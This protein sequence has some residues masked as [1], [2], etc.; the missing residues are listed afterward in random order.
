MSAQRVQAPKEAQLRALGGGRFLLAGQ[1]GGENAG[2]L[3][4]EGEAAFRGAAAVEVDLSAPT[5]ADSAGLAV[6]L[7]W[8]AVAR[9]RGATLRYVGMPTSL[10]AV[11][12]IGEVEALLRSAEGL[13]A[14]QAGQAV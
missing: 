12:R 4:A 3:L 5:H 6:L 9:R 2:V 13:P 7:E 8:V 10:A 1:I 14:P 11:A